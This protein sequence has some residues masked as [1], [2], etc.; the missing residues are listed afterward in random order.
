M[1]LQSMHLNDHNSTS[2]N[3]QDLEV[4]INRWIK[5]WYTYTIG[6]YSAIKIDEIMALQLHV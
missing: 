6:Y 2:Y 5:M 3:S 1:I 4:T